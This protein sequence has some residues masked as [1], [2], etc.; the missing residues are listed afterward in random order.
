MKTQII[1]MDIYIDML[2]DRFGQAQEW[3]GTP[4]TK[5]LWG[6]YL[7]LIKRVGIAPNDS[8]PKVVVDNYVVNSEIVSREDF[9]EG[10]FPAYCTECQT[11]EDLC[12]KAIIHNKDYAMMQVSVNFRINPK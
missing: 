10:R 9:K 6:E 2:D 3:W 7:E 5:A 4:K 1:P 11:F 8:D 12:K